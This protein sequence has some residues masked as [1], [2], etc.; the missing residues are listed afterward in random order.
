MYEQSL[1][2]RLKRLLRRLGDASSA[3]ID[4]WA[5]L[6]P[7]VRY[8]AAAV[9]HC[10]ACL[11]GERLHQWGVNTSS[12]RVRARCCEVPFRNI[13]LV[14]GLKKR[15]PCR[16]VSLGNAPTP[17]G[18]AELDS[19][20]NW[21]NLLPLNSCFGQAPPPMA[22]GGQVMPVGAPQMGKCFLGIGLSRFVVDDLENE[23][24]Y[25]IRPS[26]GPSSRFSQGGH[27]VNCQGY[28]R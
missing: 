17:V 5:F 16:R 12:Q 3:D 6:G 26:W 18:E 7:A 13:L 22:E 14:T 21:R 24:V 23:K 8:R 19:S 25:V 9:R 27:R 2:R 4:R 1:S 15:D 11:S 28:S 10:P 20:C